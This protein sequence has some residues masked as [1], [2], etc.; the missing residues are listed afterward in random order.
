MP[1]PASISDLVFCD[2]FDYYNQVYAKWTTGSGHGGGAQAGWEF[3]SPGRF[4]YGQCIQMDAAFGGPGIVA[5][6]LAGGPYGRLVAGFG[7]NLEA[8][9][10]PQ[11][12]FFTFIDSNANPLCYITFGTLGRIGFV[13]AN[14]INYFANPTTFSY[15]SWLYVEI[16][17]FFGT[18]GSFMLSVNGQEV[19]SET[20]IKTAT[21]SNSYGP[22]LYTDG[23]GHPNVLYDDLYVLAPSVEG[24]LGDSFLGDIKI[25]PLVPNGAGRLNQ[26]SQV[27]GTTGENWT[28]VDEEPPD[29]D[30]SYVYSTTPGQID[31][32]T[33]PIPTTITPVSSVYGVAVYGYARK[34]DSPARI[35]SV[36]VGNGATESF[37]EGSAL[38]S[39]YLYVQRVMPTNPLT[40]ADWNLSDFTDLQLAVKLLS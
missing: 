1:A 19:L 7:V 26:W 24:T 40:S 34:D 28:S 39:N 5:K 13:D 33:V 3:V 31:A 36:G 20:G 22:A 21:A 25:V 14:G 8:S 23:D 27:G 15:A 10:A 38:S 12:N 4:G 9:S 6:A 16:D 11:S 32:Y 2:G 30:T 35:V 18:S 17:V 29:G 37:D